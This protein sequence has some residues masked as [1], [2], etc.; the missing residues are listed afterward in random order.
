[1]S[2]S[3][4]GNVRELENAIEHALVMGTSDSILPGDLPE[5]LSNDDPAGQGASE[6]QDAVMRF[7][8]RLI[9]DALK[10]T[11]DNCTE[12]ARVLGVHP[13]YLHRLV[14]KLGIKTDSTTE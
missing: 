3:W 5:S 9:R 2:Y 8:R 11:G 1:V 10:H 4:P 12:A 7:K 6:Y 14:R 13:N